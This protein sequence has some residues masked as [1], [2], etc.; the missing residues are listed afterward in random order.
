MDNNNQTTEPK[1][2]VKTKKAK[3]PIRW[4]AIVPFI[5]FCALVSLYFKLFFDSN[6][7][8]AIEIAG[9][10]ATGAEVNVEKVETSFLDASLNIKGVELTNAEKPTHNNLYIG[11]IRFSLL[12]DALLRAKFVVQEAAVENIG[13]DQKRKR[14]G[15]VKPPEPEKESALKKEAEKLKEE[16]LNKAKSQYEDNVLGNIA[17]MMGGGTQN[18]ELDKLKGKIVSKEKIKAFEESLKNKQKDWEERLK[19][20]PKAAEFQALGD[21]MKTVKTSGFANIE[22]LNQSVSEI[23]KI[24]DEANKKVNEINSTKNDLDKDFKLTDEGLKEIKSQIEKDIKDLEAHFKIPKIDAKSIAVSLFR[25]Y[26]N[27]YLEKVNH[28]KGLIYKYAPPNLLKKDKEEPEVQIQPR[29]R[30]TGIVYEFGKPNS[31]PLFWIKKTLITSKF[32][33]TNAATSEIKLG[34]IKG[35]ITDIT[36]NQAL[37]GKPTVALVEGDFPAEG[38]MGFLTKLT[39]DNTKKDSVVIFDAKVKSYPIQ[40]KELVNSEEVQISFNKALGALNASLSLTNYK[41]ITMSI[42]SDFTQIDYL[43]GA[44]NKDV[45]GILKNV[46]QQATSANLIAKGKG[47]LPNFGLD[48]ESN[49][50]EKIQ[51]G[52]EKE[53]QA[54]IEEARQKI[55]AFVDA[56]IAKQKELIEKQVDAFKNQA[57]GEIKKAQAQAETQKKL[58][59]AKIDEAKKDFERRIEAEKQKL[60]AERKKAENEAKKK[61]EAEAKKA[62]EELKKKL[63]F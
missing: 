27:P 59:E 13:F 60:D 58:A 56:E 3:G 24:L 7:K 16:A 10:H 21:R 45:E 57:E 20:L 62:A 37:V 33:Q 1:P 6:I 29:P 22:E 42:V 41:D 31:Y 48:I 63:G 9:Y 49:L 28:Y 34:N 40:A 4:E 17:S 47:V 53:I 18:E 2:A 38:V 46:F 5:I 12:W 26:T 23:Q 36:S 51:K 19:K 15:K 44:K 61:A 32:N 11:E 54:K 14:P 52:F 43:V 39:V 35:Q 55:K 8:T 50:G 25:R 30:E